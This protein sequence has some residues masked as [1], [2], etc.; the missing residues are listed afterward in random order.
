LVTFVLSIITYNYV[1]L[2]K[3]LVNTPYSAC[4]TA[5]FGFNN[6]KFDIGVQ[7]HGPG[8]AL[9]VTVKLIVKG[10]YTCYTKE[11]SEI[12]EPNMLVNYQRRTRTYRNKV[13]SNWPVY[14]TWET[15][16]GQRQIVVYRLN[17]KEYFLKIGRC[18]RFYFYIKRFFS[19]HS[20]VINGLK[21]V[22]TPNKVKKSA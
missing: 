10:F 16:T 22:I 11:Y 12:I 1:H 8:T 3:K 2:T 5:W 18:E 15:T 4:L 7:N 20:I 14:I 6:D 13:L 19:R 17:K 9:N 21:N